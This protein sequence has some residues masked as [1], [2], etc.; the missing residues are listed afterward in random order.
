M[1]Q[2]K[3][4]LQSVWFDL[5]T[6]W[7]LIVRNHIAGSVLVPRVLRTVLYRLMGLKVHTFNIREGQIIENDNIIIG[8]G[9]FV[10]RG[11]S[12]EGSGLIS[13]G[14]GCQLGPE[15][16]FITSAHQRRADGTVNDAPT[17]G[18]IL[19]EDGAWIGARCI[20]LPGAVIEQNTIIAAGALVR[21]RCLAGKSYGGVPARL[22]EPG[23]STRTV[24]TAVT[25]AGA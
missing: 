8:T 17:Y 12:F 4:A 6:A 3:K 24:E 5:G 13:I 10:N 20:I 19:V 11:C 21:G 2:A 23:S 25:E 14:A 22:L 15:S 9:T 7:Y 1:S 16:M 18:D